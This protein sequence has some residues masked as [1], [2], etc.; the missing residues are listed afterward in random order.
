MILSIM[1]HVLARI[2][3]VKVSEIKQQLVS[4]MKKHTEH[5]LHLKHLWQNADDD[6]EVFFIFRT[7]DLDKARKFIDQVHKHVLATDSN[8]NLPQM[9]FLEEI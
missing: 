3:G 1:A 6:N 9:T 8:A 4:D 5:G 2:R 7:T